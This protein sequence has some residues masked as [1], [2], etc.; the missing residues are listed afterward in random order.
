VIVLVLAIGAGA[1][2]IVQS[3]KPR[4]F[5][6]AFN[7]S[8]DNSY[9]TLQYGFENMLKTDSHLGSGGNWGHAEHQKFTGP[10][11]ARSHD[12]PHRVPH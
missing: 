8:G 4:E 11:A 12:L 2:Y 7:M 6:I 1:V 3:L 10:K 9:G 5:D